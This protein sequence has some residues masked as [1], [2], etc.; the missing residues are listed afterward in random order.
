VY[1]AIKSTLCYNQLV[2]QCSP[3][4]S[5]TRHQPYW[6]LEP[7][8]RSFQQYKRIKTTHTFQKVFKLG[9][10]HQIDII[11]IGHVGGLSNVLQSA[12]VNKPAL[13]LVSNYLDNW[14]NSVIMMNATEA[15]IYESHT[16]IND[17]PTSQ[18]LEALP[19]LKI[20][21]VFHQIGNVYTDPNYIFL[22]YR[23]TTSSRSSTSPIANDL[24]QKSIIE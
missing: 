12:D 13:L 23:P 7:T 9:E 22:Y 18:I 3:Q 15:T 2:A 11:G 5:V 10:T 21:A 24:V 8:N 14:P 16:V 4:I 1:N 20:I 6:I 17:L 19:N